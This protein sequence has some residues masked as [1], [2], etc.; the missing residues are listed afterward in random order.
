MYCKNCGAPVDDMQ[1][2]VMCGTKVEPLTL[3][4]QQPPT[5]NPPA[6]PGVNSFPTA[7]MAPWRPQNQS[8]GN[9]KT[10]WKKVLICVSVF[11]VIEMIASLFL[12]PILFDPKIKIMRAIEKTFFEANSFTFYQ[13]YRKESPYGYIGIEDSISFAFGDT[14]ADTSMCYDIETSEGDI[15]I[16]SYN[17]DL[18]LIIESG[19]FTVGAGAAVNDIYKEFVD[20]PE[21]LEDYEV[22]FDYFGVDQDDFFYVFSNIVSDRKLNED[23]LSVLFDN[24]IREAFASYV[25]AYPDDF[26]DYN[27]LKNFITKFMETGVSDDTF[28]IE[29]SSRKASTTYYDVTID[30]SMLIED[31]LEFCDDSAYAESFVSTDLG[32]RM[33]DGF[34]ENEDEFRGEELEFE[35]GISNGYL[36]ELNYYSDAI[37]LEIV[38]S[39]INT[40]ETK[41]K[42]RYDELRDEYENADESEYINDE[43]E[44]E[45]ILLD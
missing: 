40:A 22:I 6:Q 7:P 9:K 2:C 8:A 45:E 16:A 15:N 23:G 26:P 13:Y 35:V 1:F 36:T 29:K 12:T 24:F 3:K 27:T 31:F 33:V 28:K 42:E 25:G 39:D 19:G 17:G 11:L 14:L 10:W 21:K 43:D 41:I 20:D 30:F 32:E 38:I 18:V 4:T 44:L 34:E 37:D 5:F